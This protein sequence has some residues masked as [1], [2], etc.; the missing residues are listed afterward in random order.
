MD[1]N[2]ANFGLRY[3]HLFDKLPSL[4]LFFETLSL[5]L[6]DVREAIIYGV[7]N[8]FSIYKLTVILLRWVRFTHRD[9]LNQNHVRK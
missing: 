3:K 2:Y 4:R 8:G 7:Q 9:Q 6:T 1:L 5:T